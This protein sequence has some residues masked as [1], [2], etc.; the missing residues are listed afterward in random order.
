MTQDLSVVDLDI[1]K[2]IFHLVGMDDRGK[3]ILRK[4][5][6]RGEVLSF[7]SQLPPVTV[8]IEACGGAHEWERRLR[9]LERCPRCHQGALRIIA[10]ITYRP[11]IRRL[12][13]PLQLAAPPSCPGPLGARAFRL[14]PCITYWG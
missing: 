3:V 4:R 12:L 9:E 11:V 10:A 14:D 2:R 5:L 8:G 6:V 7:M 13:G 1:A